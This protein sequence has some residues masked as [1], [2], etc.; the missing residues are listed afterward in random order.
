LLSIS[1]R[2]MM[3]LK[4]RWVKTLRRLFSHWR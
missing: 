3:H 4:K 1:K 2:S